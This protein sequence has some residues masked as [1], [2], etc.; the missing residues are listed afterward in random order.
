MDRL[1]FRHL[2]TF[3]LNSKVLNRLP[4]PHLHN[5]S[6]VLDGSSSFNGVMLKLYPTSQLGPP[7]ITSSILYIPRHRVLSMNM[8]IALPI[9][10][11]LPS[12]NISALCL[13]CL[14]ASSSLPDQKAISEWEN[15]I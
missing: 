5:S 9:Y 15:H 3:Q 2:I 10:S 6:Q 7:V 14:F 12:A 1:L 8:L 4:T 11:L 13:I